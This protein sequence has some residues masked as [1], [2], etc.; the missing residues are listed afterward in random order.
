[1]ADMVFVEI[2]DFMVRI[3]PAIRIYLENILPGDL[4]GEGMTLSNLNN[5][6]F[7]V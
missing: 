3:L 5:A 2:G 4:N 6:F 1:M 7:L